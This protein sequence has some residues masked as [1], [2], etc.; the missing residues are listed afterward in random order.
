MSNFFLTKS[1]QTFSNHRIH[2]KLLV[3][4]IGLFNLEGT[5]SR[6]QKIQKY[7]TNLIRCDLYI[8]TVVPLKKSRPITV[9]GREIHISDTISTV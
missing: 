1:Y 6:L 3:N 9:S 8:C 2:E 4:L 7:R 5:F